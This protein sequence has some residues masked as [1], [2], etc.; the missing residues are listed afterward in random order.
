[1]IKTA[2]L[3]IALLSLAGCAGL[4][5]SATL[6]ATYDF[7]LAPAKPPIVLPVRFSGVAAA[8]GLSG[9]D[10]RYRLA[11]RDGSEVHAYS[12]SRWVAPP[13]ELLSQE[14]RQSFAF[15]SASA[16]R[17]S[18]ELMRFDQVFER[19]T[20]SHAS[21]QL[22]AVVRGGGNSAQR[23]FNLDLAAVS[24]DAPGGVSALIAG[25]RQLLAPLAQWV[26][27]LECKPSPAS[28]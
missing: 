24:P 9:T 18:L 13:A 20:D 16:C 23:Q 17:L 10:M 11:Y 19:A 15:E 28:P 26:Q 8:P 21:I 12:N 3:S 2:A 5:K 1:M 6:V 25:S 4:S 7:G 22:N 27:Q 14:L